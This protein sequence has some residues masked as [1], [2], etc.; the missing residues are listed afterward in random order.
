I[1]IDKPC[2]QN[3]FETCCTLV[4]LYRLIRWHYM[5]PFAWTKTGKGVLADTT[6]KPVQAAW[7]SACI[8][9][10]SRSDN[11]GSTFTSLY[12]GW[13]LKKF[14]RRSCS[15]R[16]YRLPGFAD[17]RTKPVVKRK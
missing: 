6:S 17:L 11:Q 13:H 8:R 4:P 3:R 2:Y 10:N 12:F 15:G 9:H 14:V 7:L 16:L 5:H 1:L